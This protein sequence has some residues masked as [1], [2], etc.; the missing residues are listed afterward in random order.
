M[1]PQPL[2]F[3]SMASR[4]RYIRRTPDINSEV[5][6][7]MLNLLTYTTTTTTTSIYY[8]YTGAGRSDKDDEHVHANGLSVFR[9]HS[10]AGHGHR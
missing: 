10:E 1:V 3:R 8:H 2:F 9:L 6:N 7:S 4:L 5:R